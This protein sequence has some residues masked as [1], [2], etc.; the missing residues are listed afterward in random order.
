MFLHVDKREQMCSTRLPHPQQKSGKLLTFLM[1]GRFTGLGTAS[2]GPEAA[3]EDLVRCVCY[4]LV[5]MCSV[6]GSTGKFVLSTSKL[7][8]RGPPS[9]AKS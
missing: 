8:Q 9:A 6:H 1:E 4:K 2:L 3:A 7:I 5:S